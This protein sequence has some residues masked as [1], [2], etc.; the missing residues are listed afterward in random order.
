MFVGSLFEYGENRP[1]NLIDPDGRQPVPLTTTRL[2][3]IAQ[4]QGIGRGLGGVAL[5][6]AIGVAF[7]NWVLQSLGMVPRNTRLFYSPARALATGGLPAS[8]IPEAVRPI[9][10]Y[11]LALGFWP[12]TTV[13]PDSSLYEVK[14]VRGTITLSHSSHQIRGLIDVA[15]RSAAGTSIDPDRPRPILTFITTGDTRIGADVIA[16]ATRRGVAIWQATIME[17]TTASATNPT[18]SIG[19][20]I[21]LNPTVYGAGARP[22]PIVKPHVP[23][24]LTSTILP[25]V[26]VPHDPDP[27]E[28]H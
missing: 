8:V 3:Y 20:F 16:E 25:P 6:R 4:A 26:P 2:R 24:S 28:V 19:P 14:A 11:R 13:Y 12:T 10:G 17:D 18:L 15:A 9:T 27:A 23:A 21:P 22:V 1:L 5:N 7:E